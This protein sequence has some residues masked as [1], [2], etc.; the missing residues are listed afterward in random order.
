MFHDNLIQ[1]RKLKGLTQ[2]ALAE[3]VGVTRQAIAKWEAGDSVPDLEKC[4]L[5]AETFGVTLDDLANYEPDAEIGQN[6]PPPKGKHLFGVVTV[7]DKGQIVI[8]AKARKIFQI[9]PG[10]A[11]VVLGDEGSGLAILKASSFL[12]MADAIR[13]QSQ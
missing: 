8:P 9:A 3:K 10:D 6:A 2:E 4:R 12:S 7:G 11:L 13:K 5:L 1:L